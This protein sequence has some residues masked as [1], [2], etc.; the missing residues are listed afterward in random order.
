[1]PGDYLKTVSGLVAVLVICFSQLLRIYRWKLIVWKEG[2]VSNRVLSRSIG[3]SYLANL[4]LPFRMGELI[5]IGYL[6]RKKFGTAATILA[7]VFERLVDSILLTLVFGVY[8]Y[9]SDGDISKL[10]V[11]SF[12]AA[13]A[14][15]LSLY[16]L[17]K[18]KK[19]RLKAIQ[20][21]SE[22][23]Q[24]R[25][26]YLVLQIYLVISKAKINSFPIFIYSIIINI[27]IFSSI[28]LFS[29]SIGR[30]V[31]EI[32]E[33]LIF[34]LSNSISVALLQLDNLSESSFISVL[35]LVLPICILL[36][37]SFRELNIEGDDLAKLQIDKIRDLFLPESRNS[38]ND[39]YVKELVSSIT[40]AGESQLSKIQIETLKGVKLKE[41]IQGGGSGDYVFLV[42]DATR[43]KV[44]K[45]ASAS[46]RFF[47][48]EQNKW[49]Q[50]YGSSV[51]VVQTSNL[52]TTENAAY[53][54]MEYLGSE[55]SFFEKLHHSDLNE[56]KQMLS[57]LL[58][59][60]NVESH[61]FLTD[62][63]GQT[64]AETY[65]EKLN[66][67][68]NIIKEAGL[69]EYLGNSLKHQG[70]ELYSIEFGEMLKF[71]SSQDLPAPFDWITHGDLTVS[72]L[73]V[74][75]EGIKLIDPNPIQPFF[76]P[77]VDFGKLLQSFKCGYEFDFKNPKVVG[78]GSNTKIL[79]TKSAVYSEMEDYLYKWIEKNN[80]FE[81]IYHSR[82]QLL[83]HLI[84]IVPYTNNR[85]QHIWLI[86]QIR[87]C[88][89]EL[90]QENYKSI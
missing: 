25:I 85:N 33:I 63:S 79:G 14:V 84:R 3:I 40:T 88:F 2:N 37:P 67:S 15:L 39:N 53:Y 28:I 18:P 43:I 51:S 60:L 13:A 8:F 45:S 87:I 71:L 19:R 41:V 26:N 30:S 6:R 83:L 56:C 7:V 68:F 17:L 34:N 70:T 81:N 22:E 23:L 1:M 75:K 12:C 61:D 49:M 36:V 55:S 44:R 90:I 48:G 27:G 47:L 58:F 5:R 21:F 89:T 24:M 65:E 11:V 80:K 73:L 4:I 59:T 31:F 16:L 10:L 35:Y 74:D 9:I 69:G 66:N 42:I 77:T 46:R 78:E 82:I 86:I 38:N 29:K 62:R 50:G 64:Y 57:H 72:N 76:H 54:D 32:T 52:F 20:I